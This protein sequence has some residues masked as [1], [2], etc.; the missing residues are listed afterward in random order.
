MATKDTITTGPFTSNDSITWNDQIYGGSNTGGSTTIGPYYYPPAT[1]PGYYPPSTNPYP[2]PYPPITE[3]Q[4]D[5]ETL[6]QLLEALKLEQLEKD[7]RECP[8]C[9]QTTTKWTDDDYICDD[10]RGF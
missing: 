4:Y 9:E 7:G 10:C 2:N 8:K 5:I 6:E 1:S 3:P